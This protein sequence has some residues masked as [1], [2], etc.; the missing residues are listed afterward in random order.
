MHDDDGDDVG[1]DGD[2]DHDNDND[3]GEELSLLS[4]WCIHGECVEKAG[5]ATAAGS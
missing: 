5:S 4:Q 1:D 3:D 2:D